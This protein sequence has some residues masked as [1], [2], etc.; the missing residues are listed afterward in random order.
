VAIS[1]PLPQMESRIETAALRRLQ[2]V[3]VPEFPLD[4]APPAGGCKFSLLS[5]RHHFNN[6]YISIPNSEWR[7]RQDETGHSYVIVST[8]ES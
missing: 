1:V 2:P 6:A 7:A 3:Q 8:I 4:A 5:A